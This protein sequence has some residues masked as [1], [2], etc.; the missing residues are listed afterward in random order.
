MKSPGSSPL[1]GRQFGPSRDAGGRP[2]GAPLR[3]PH[4]PR[5]RGQ[6]AGLTRSR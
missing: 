6:D 5:R 2:A 1:P 3:A 4:R